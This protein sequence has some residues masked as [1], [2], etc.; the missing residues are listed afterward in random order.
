MEKWKNGKMEKWKNIN[1]ISCEIERGLK[2]NLE[3]ISI[4]AAVSATEQGIT[5]MVKYSS[6]VL[7][8]FAHTDPTSQYRTYDKVGVPLM[9]SVVQL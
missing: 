2:S 9:V 1:A 8:T 3:V 7:G 4:P 5:R 6:P